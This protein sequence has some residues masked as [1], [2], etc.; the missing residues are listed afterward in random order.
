VLQQGFVE[1]SNVDVLQEFVD[2]ILFAT[3]LRI[4][5]TRGE[6]RR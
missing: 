2:M 5:F 1:Q 6:S 3:F 4:E